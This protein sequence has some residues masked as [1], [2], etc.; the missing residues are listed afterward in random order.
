MPSLLGVCQASLA[1]TFTKLVKTVPTRPGCYVIFWAASLPLTLP[2]LSVALFGFPLLSGGGSLS[3]SKDDFKNF[4]SGL[5]KGMEPQGAR[6]EIEVADGLNRA[7]F[8]EL[9]VEISDGE[10]PS[11]SGNEKQGQE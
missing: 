9:A 5:K 6:V 7:A 10:S 4:F 1:T 11:Q 3:F 8:F 2:L